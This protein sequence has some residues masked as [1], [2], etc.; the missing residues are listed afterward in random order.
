MSLTGFTRPTGTNAPKQRRL[1][2]AEVDDVDAIPAASSGVVNSDITMASGKYFVECKIVEE[3]AKAIFRRNGAENDSTNYDHVFEGMVAASNATNK[4]ALEGLDNKRVIAI[5]EG[6][7]N[8]NMQ[9]LGE[10]T[11][12]LKCLTAESQDEEDNGF[13]LVLEGKGYSHAPYDY[14]GTVTTA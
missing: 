10:K 7:N 8:G 13:P 12:G 2:L 9:I 14:T 11:K 5:V 6:N 4:I 3:T 1:W